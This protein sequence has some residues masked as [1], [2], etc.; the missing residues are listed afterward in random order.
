M[1]GGNK[2][3]AG[4]FEPRKTDYDRIVR[5]QLPGAELVLGLVGPVG[6]NLRK[7]GKDLTKCLERYGYD[8]KEIHVSRLIQNLV[9]IPEHNP[10]SEF[11]RAN[12]L[13]TAGNDARRITENNAILALGAVS[14]IYADREHVGR[15]PLPQSRQA[16]IINSL[17]HPAEVNAL[18]RIYGSAFFLIGVYSEPERRREWLTTK[19]DQTMSLDE[20]KR[21]IRRDEAE[22]KDH[23]QRTRDTYHLSDFFVHL[24]Y[25]CVFRRFRPLVPKES[26]R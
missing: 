16:Y 1:E 19:K 26:A 3:Q 4:A 6:V 18:R 7:I 21:L 9:E 11:E 17:K 12:A 5:G 10:D 22:G 14:A 25:D 23:G 2:S 15:K 24:R 13:M 20:A 8:C